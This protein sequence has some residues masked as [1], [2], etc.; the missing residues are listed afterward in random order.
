MLSSS[1]RQI[2]VVA[3][4]HQGVDAESWKDYQ[5]QNRTPS[6]RPDYVDYSQKPHQPLSSG[7]LKLPFMRPSEECRTFRSPAVEKVINDK[8][9]PI[10]N[11]DVARLFE[12]AFPSMLDTTVKYFDAKENLA[13]IVAGDYAELVTVNQPYDSQTV[14]ECKYELH[15]LAGFLTFGR[16]SYNNT[17]DASFIDDNCK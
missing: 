9:K 12:N 13:F 4:A 14:F 8:K 10:R 11:P 3:L 2:L 1:A 7:K 15:S 16:S 17:K 5:P 6:S